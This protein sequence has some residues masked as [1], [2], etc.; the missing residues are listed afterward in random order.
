L[1]AVRAFTLIE[2]V[3]VIV[4]LGLTAS[5]IVPRMN[6]SLGHRELREAAARF[7][8]TART[9]RELAVARQQLF[10]ITI[11]L[12]KGYGVIM[13]SKKEP[14][15]MQKVQTSWLKP[16]RWP[17]KLEVRQFRTPDGASATSGVQK[18]EFY[19]DG[20]SSGASLVL[21]CDTDEY[22][23]VVHQHNGRV[24]YGDTET[25]RIAPDQYDLGD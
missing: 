21:A 13:Q 22:V 23:I 8:Q 3:V 17:E 4:L 11:D 1:A 20:T 10:A 16:T 19:K 18:L 14:G 9:V 12:D 15:V 7:A 25:S 6:R 5:L 2:V 24:I